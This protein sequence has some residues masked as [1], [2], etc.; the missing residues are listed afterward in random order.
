MFK[1]KS[2]TPTLCYRLEYVFIHSPAFFWESSSYAFG[3]CAH[4][5]SEP[6]VVVT[7]RK[8]ILLRY[9]YLVRI[10]YYCIGAYIVIITSCLAAW[11]GG[12][13]EFVSSIIIVLCESCVSSSSSSI[14]SRT[15]PWDSQYQCVTV[16][17]CVQF[18]GKLLKKL[19]YN[20][21]FPH[22]RN[23]FSCCNFKGDIWRVF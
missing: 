12:G 20:S 17:E 19:L 15:P 9:L 18:D 1:T 6:L 7:F 21:L 22:G 10:C 5:H 23:T 13:F 2:I 8:I 4:K 16:P 3:K 14:S 11:S